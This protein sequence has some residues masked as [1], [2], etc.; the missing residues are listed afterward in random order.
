MARSEIKHGGLFV[1][2]ASLTFNPR[3]LLEEIQN[4]PE[5]I[6]EKSGHRF[7]TCILL[8]G[9]SGCNHSIPETP[10][11]Q[12]GCNG[13]NGCNDSRQEETIILEDKLARIEKLFTTC[14]SVR[15]RPDYK[16]FSAVTKMHERLAFERINRERTR[17]YTELLRLNRSR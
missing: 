5:S 3:A 6:S 17:L 13:F 9:C 1:L 12:C 7:E 8:N 11:A 2:M 10:T 15:R 16:H 14:L 4:R